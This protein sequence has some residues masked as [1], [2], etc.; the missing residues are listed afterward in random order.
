MAAGAQVPRRPRRPSCRPMT[1]SRCWRRRGLGPGDVQGCLRVDQ[2]KE[3]G[4]QAEDLGPQSHELSESP[5]FCAVLLGPDQPTDL[6]HLCRPPKLLQLREHLGEALVRRGG[7]R[8][9]DG[10]LGGGASALGLLQ[11][12]GPAECPGGAHHNAPATEVVTDGAYWA[13][14][15]GVVV[16][17]LMTA[18]LP[19]RHE[20]RLKSRQG[21]PGMEI[22]VQELIQLP[23]HQRLLRHADWH[24]Q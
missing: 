4:L 6:A 9:G 13:V 24:G 22:V 15:Y 8:R 16:D 20:F 2:S 3:I 5:Q 23:R 14:R 17:E 11:L 1:H 21:L 19:H 10:P 18:L 12:G 7:H